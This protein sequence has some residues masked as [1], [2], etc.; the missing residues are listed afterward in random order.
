MRDNKKSF[1][2]YQERS[3]LKPIK[4]T[5]I[6]RTVM[7]SQHVKDVRKLFYDSDGIYVLPNW[8]LYHANLNGSCNKVYG[9]LL[10]KCYRDSNLTSLVTNM[11]N[12]ELSDMLSLD[13][14]TISR[15][16]NRLHKYGAI[17][18]KISKRKIDGRYSTIRKIKVNIEPK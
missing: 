13:E 18:S 6:R 2:R 16:I 4:N 11:S 14:K 7:E 15:T 3:K 9:V 10:R 8:V 17:E 12:K 5:K 1:I